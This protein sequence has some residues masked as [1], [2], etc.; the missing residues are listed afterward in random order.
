MKIDALKSVIES[1]YGWSDF[2]DLCRDA[3]DEEVHK[4]SSHWMECE[5]NFEEATGIS[6][7]LVSHELSYC[8][9]GADVYV[10]FQFNGSGVYQVNAWWDS[11][12]D[13]DFCEIRNTLVRVKPIPKTIIT[14]EP[15]EDDEE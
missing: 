10:R 8:P 5:K 13:Y 1:K 3:M 4:P 15:V 12:E 7:S 2:E 14:Y 11:Y 9:D 6:I